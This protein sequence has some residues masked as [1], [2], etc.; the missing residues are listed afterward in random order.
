[1]TRITKIQRAAL[2]EL[3]DGKW[4]SLSSFAI[5]TIV[6]LC[7]RCFIDPIRSDYRYFRGIGVMVDFRITPAG[8]EALGLVP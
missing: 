8:R 5:K 4:H 1:M 3:T 2:M 7:E 6:S